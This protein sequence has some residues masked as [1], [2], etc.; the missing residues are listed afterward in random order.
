M[1]ARALDPDTR[2]SDA[3]A[4]SQ[5]TAV[6][7][8]RKAGSLINPLRRR[9]LEALAVPGSATT[10]ADT[11]QVPRQLV[12]YH[13]RVL[14]KAGLLEQV[15]TRRRRGLTERIV[16]ATAMHYLVSP[17]SVGVEP[18]SADRFSSTFQVAVAARTIR[19]VA[20]LAELAQDAGKRLTT[21]TLD[22]TVTFASPADREAFGNDLVTAINTLT[23]KYNAPA[24][25][26]ARSY[27]L[28][29]GAHPEYRPSPTKDSANAEA[30]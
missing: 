30:E 20:A 26:T 8:G 28:F 6:V 18:Q 27:R 3:E 13:L 1:A 4:P 7:Q 12:N 17:E 24:G 23:A 5:G 2:T 22:T 9:I 16:R 21:L 25:S 19:E 15:A 29:V 14:E 11:L 10:V